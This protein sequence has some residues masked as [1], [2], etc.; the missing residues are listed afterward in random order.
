MN[1]LIKLHEHAEGK[2]SL[3]GLS[4]LPNSF[5]PLFVKTHFLSQLLH[6]P[7]CL[8]AFDSRAAALA[9]S[10]GTLGKKKKGLAGISSSS[11]TAGISSVNSP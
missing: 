5:L 10:T 8:L 9:F 11:D 7:K 6:K 3:K 2:H 1:H 4:L